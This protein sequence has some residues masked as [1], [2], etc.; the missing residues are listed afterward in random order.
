M[1]TVTQAFTRRVRGNEL[2]RNLIPPYYWAAFCA[3]SD[4]WI[5]SSLLR[6]S[7]FRKR[8]E[9]GPIIRRYHVTKN[10]V[11][12][13]LSRKCLRHGKHLFSRRRGRTGR[14]PNRQ[15]NLGRSRG[16]R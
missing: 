4:F 15:G 14:G 1:F 8:A 6:S 3:F 12:S 16:T 9:S 7:E 10:L 11:P 13:H 2:L 5:R